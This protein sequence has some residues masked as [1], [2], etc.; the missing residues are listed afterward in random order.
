MAH[1]PVVGNR[2]QRLGEKGFALPMAIFL[3]IVLGVSGLSFHH[4]DYL[5]KRMSMG[6]GD[7]LDSFYLANAGIERARAVLKID[8]VSLSWTPFLTAGSDTPAPDPAM[9]RPTDDPSL[10]YVIPPFGDIITGSSGDLPFDGLFDDGQYQVRIFNNMSAGETGTTDLDGIVTIR[11]LGTVRGEQKLVEVDIRAVSGLKLI[12]WV[13]P[14][15]LTYHPNADIDPSPGREITDPVP[16]IPMMSPALT[17]SGNFYRTSSNFPLTVRA[18]PSSGP[19][20]DNSYYFIDNPGSNQRVDG[21]NNENTPIQNV[22]IF[23][24]GSIELHGYFENAIAVGVEGVDVKGNGR[25]I[26][27]PAPGNSQYPAII[28]GANIGGGDNG[29]NIIGTIYAI[30]DIDINPI[31]VEGTIIAGGDIKLQ[32]AATSVTDAGILDY[33]ELM[34]GFTYPDELKTTVVVSGGFSWREIE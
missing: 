25:I 5:E 2:K 22:V 4:L 24:T 8:D 15:D 21:G 30:G 18:F 28:S 34:P 20:Q 32:S 7:N 12:N 3:V 17:D 13:D 6:T 9:L 10:K 26:S 29:F 31:H 19:L 27:M 14:N 1:N 11:A 33:Y 16:S 23:A